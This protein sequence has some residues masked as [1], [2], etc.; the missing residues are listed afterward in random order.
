ML[1]F[2]IIDTRNKKCFYDVTNVWFDQVNN[3]LMIKKNASKPD[4]VSNN[5]ATTVRKY[6]EI[7]TLRDLSDLLD[8]KKVDFLKES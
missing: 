7:D 4:V 1:A 6:K 8:K 3:K 2:K 5:L